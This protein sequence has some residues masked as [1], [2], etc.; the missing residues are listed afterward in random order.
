[1]WGRNVFMALTMLCGAA[2][3]SFPV[4]ADEDSPRV[5]MG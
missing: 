1:M 2:A 3:L 4:Y 5:K